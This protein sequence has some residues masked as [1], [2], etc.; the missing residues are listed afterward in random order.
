VALPGDLPLVPC[1]PVLIEQTLI[2]L[3]ENAAKYG[4]GSI[5]VGATFTAAEVVVE[6]A[7]RGPG[8]PAGE[9]RRIFEKFQRGAREGSPDGVGLGLTI[10][11]AIVA[12]HGGRIWVSNRDG[13]GASF[14]FA[15][16]IEGE[17]LPM[18]APE[19]TDA[20]LQEPI[21]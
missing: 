14:R 18:P 15:L 20:P 1:D 2:N 19:S 11:R 10:C 12:A 16:P 13:G 5:D 7:D 3:L 17:A 9:E 4:A 6:V 8:V 21:A